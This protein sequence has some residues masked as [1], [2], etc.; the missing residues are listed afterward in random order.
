MAEQEPEPV[1][2]A[3]QHAARDVKL[4]EFWPT[5]PAAWFRLAESRFR[6]RHVDD[7]LVM[8]DHLLSA[9]PEDVIAAVLDVLEEV[10][11]DEP[12]TILKDRLLETHVLSDFEKMELLFKVPNLGARKPSQLLTSMMEVCPTNEEKSKIFLF[13]FMQRLPKD[14][15]LMMGNVEAGDPRT[16]AAKADRLWACHARQMDSTV[17]VVDGEREEDDSIVAAV[18]NKSHQKPGWTKAQWKKGHKG[19]RQQQ[20]QH[21]KYGGGQQQQRHEKNAP[22]DIAIA[23]SGLCRAHWFNGEKARQCTQGMT[24]SWQEN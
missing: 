14:L 22:M 3:G 4:P 19:D 15:R 11:E 8:F 24:C 18:G 23:A 17:A 6:L 5:R 9:L 21:Q 2:A 1:P 16:V 10:G 12:Y 20:Q 13:M 7:Q